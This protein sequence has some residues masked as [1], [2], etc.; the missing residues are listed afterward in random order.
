MKIPR[1]FNDGDYKKTQQ[2]GCDEISMPFSDVGDHGSY[3][4]TR[5]YRVAQGSYRPEQ[6][7]ARIVIS[8]GLAYLV[9]ESEARNIGNGILEFTRTYATI[10]VTRNWES[11][12]IAYTRQYPSTSASYDWTTAPPTPEI[13]EVTVPM[14][15]RLIYEYS[16]TRF[17]PI[18]APRVEVIFGSVVSFGGWGTLVEGQYYAAED[19]KTDV[20]KGRIYY[21]RTIAIKWT[22]F[23]RIS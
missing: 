11:T 18:I 19:S 7:M 10:P 22:N 21:R 5:T 6:A 4:I 23:V 17:E 20:Y 15:A 14:S 16:L 13:T 8:S 9:N 12:T 3:E 1:Y 2:V